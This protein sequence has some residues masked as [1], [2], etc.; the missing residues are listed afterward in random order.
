MIT[1]NVFEFPMLQSPFS[2][3]IYSTFIKKKLK[4]NL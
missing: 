4:Y 1:N 3:G 2:S